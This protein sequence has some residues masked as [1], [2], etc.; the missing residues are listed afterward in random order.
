MTPIV[1]SGLVWKSCC[2]LVHSYRPRTVGLHGEQVCAIVGHRHRPGPVEGAY[3]V[4]EPHR[5]H[6]RSVL[7]QQVHDEVGVALMRKFYPV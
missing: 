5:N 3:L 4:D 2:P 1:P 7:V 6:R